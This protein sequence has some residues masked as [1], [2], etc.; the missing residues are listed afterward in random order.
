M[1]TT[2]GKLELLILQEINTAE[3]EIQCTTY[4]NDAKALQTKYIYNVL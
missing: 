4:D 3:L 1:T 2:T